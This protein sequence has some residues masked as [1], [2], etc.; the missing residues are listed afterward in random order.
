MSIIIE[1]LQKIK[2]SEFKI[3]ESPVIHKNRKLY[4][5]NFSPLEK[6]QLRQI[7]RLLFNEYIIA[8][9]KWERIGAREIMAKIPHPI[10]NDRR[11]SLASYVGKHFIPLMKKSPR[12][13]AVAKK[14][15][16]SLL[17][18]ISI[19]ELLQLEIT[20]DKHP[21]F[22]TIKEIEDT[23]ENPV[24]DPSIKPVED[25]DVIVRVPIKPTIVPPVL[26]S[27][28]V[29]KNNELIA[30][31]SGLSV[32]EKSKFN[33][34]HKGQVMDTKNAQAVFSKTMDKRKLAKINYAKGL[35]DLTK[36]DEK[37]TEQLFKTLG[38]T[39]I[40]SI[41]KKKTLNWK[42]I[43]EKRFGKMLSKKEKIKK[44]D[45]FEK[46][47]AQTFPTDFVTARVAK[48][49]APFKKFMMDNTTLDIF[50]S[51][52]NKE[53]SKQYNWKNVA[54]KDQ[55]AVRKEIQTFQRVQNLTSDVRDIAPLANS[56]YTSASAI[57]TA[58]RQ[59]FY[60]NSGLSLGKSKQVYQQAL[61]VNNESLAYL[62]MQLE[63]YRDIDFSVSNTSEITNKEK[64]TLGEI[65]YQEIFGSLHF[66]EC[67]HCNSV[68]SPAAYFVDLL[69]FLKTNNTAAFAE[70]T[71]RRADLLDIQL[72]C[73]QTLTTQP[74]LELVNEVLGK[75]LE[76][77]V[78]NIPNLSREIDD[79]LYLPWINPELPFEE[80]CMKA[81]LLANQLDT[82]LF[83][84][85]NMMEAAPE[86]QMAEYLGLGPETLKWMFLPDLLP[87]SSVQKYA[88]ETFL[89]LFN[90]DY[91]ELNLI[92]NSPVG[93]K[94]SIEVTKIDTQSYTEKIV[95]SGSSGQVRANYL[96]KLFKF[97]R[98]YRHLNYQL[99]DLELYVDL[100]TNG[101][102]LLNAVNLSKF[103]T[104][105]YVK[106]SLNLDNNALAVL[107]RGYQEEDYEFSSTQLNQKDQLVYAEVLSLLSISEIDFERLVDAFKDELNFS[108]KELLLDVNN[109][110]LLKRNIF[111]A[112][113]AGLSMKD[114]LTFLAINNTLKMV[115]N[116]NWITL[117]TQIKTYSGIGVPISLVDFYMND[118]QNESWYYSV[119]EDSV[120]NWLTLLKDGKT[121]F[122]DVDELGVAVAE[123]FGAD[124][125]LI[126]LLF[127]QY[128][129]KSD[130]LLDSVS[131]LLSLEGELDT[132]LPEFTAALDELKQLDKNILLLDF[133]EINLEAMAYFFDKVDRFGINPTNTKV[134]L[135]SLY[136]FS[137]WLNGLDGDLEIF[138]ALFDGTV[139]S[140][141][142]SEELKVIAESVFELDVSTVQKLLGAFGWDPL[143][144]GQWNR[145]FNAVELC[146]ELNWS[147]EKLEYMLQTDLITNKPREYYQQLS[148]FFDQSIQLSGKSADQMTEL[149]SEVNNKLIEA[150]RD[151]IVALVKKSTVDR[152]NSTAKIYAHF[153][154]DSE[155]SACAEV[156]PIKAAI[157]SVQL[158]IH[159]CLLNVENDN[160]GNKLQFDD[161]AKKEWEWRKNFRVWEANRK[162]FLYPENYLDPDL[163][164]DKTAI[165]EDL[166][167][168]LQQ[169]DLTLQAIEKT[170]RKYLKEF[171]NVAK[172]AMAGSFKD[173]QS[174]LYYYFGRT[175]NKPYQ[176]Y[177][178]TYAKSTRTWSPW[179]SIEVNIS[180]D[181]LAGIVVS[182]RVYIFWKELKEYKSATISDG[183]ASEYKFFRPVINYAYMEEDLGWS[184]PIEVEVKYTEVDEVTAYLED[185]FG[186]F[187]KVEQDGNLFLITITSE[188]TGGGYTE[189][190]QVEINIPENRFERSFD[191]S[192]D[193]IGALSA[194]STE[195]GI[196]LFIPSLNITEHHM[197][198]ANV[199]TRRNSETEPII[200][201]NQPLSIINGQN[202]NNYI[203]KNGEKYY[204]Y[205]FF[206]DGLYPLN[207]YVVNELS[208]VLFMDG[209]DIFLDPATQINKTEITD[210]VIHEDVILHPNNIFLP[211]QGLDFD[212]PNGIYFQELYFHIPFTLA[213]HYNNNNKYQEADYWFK[214]LFDPTI[215]FD[216]DQKYWQYTPFRTD[217]VEQMKSILQNTAALSKYHENP[218]NP[219]AIA[220]LRT[221]A[222]PKAIIMNYIDNLLDWGDSLFSQ[223][224]YESIN[225]AMMLYITA[226][227]L[228]GERPR[229]V[230]VCETANE[231]KTF[232]QIEEFLNASDEI[233]IEIESVISENKVISNSKSKFSLDKEVSDNH[234]QNKYNFTDKIQGNKSKGPIYNDVTLIQSFTQ[235]LFCIPW[236]EN[237]LGYWDLV[238]NRMYK[239]R[240][241]MN[242]DG[243]Y[244]QLALFEPPIDPNL[245]VRARSAGLN[246]SQLTAKTQ[247]LPYRFSYLLEKARFFANTV[248]S[249]GQAMLSA[250]EKESGEALS[251]LR[252]IHEGNILEMVTL[253]KEKL[254]DE[255]NTQTEIND[256]NTEKIQ[257]SIAYYQELM[258]G[259]VSGDFKIA[260]QK[261][262]VSM[263][264]SKTA[265]LLNL[266]SS[267]LYMIPQLG[268][269]TA[270]TF[271]GK[272]S[273]DSAKSGT[274]ALIALGEY[275][276]MGAEI[277]EKYQNQNIRNL[278]WKNGFDSSQK[279]LKT[280]EK[281]KLVNEIKLAVAQRDLETHKQRIAQNEEA[282]DFYTEKMS[283]QALYNHLK[284]HLTRLYRDAYG[285]AMQTA[286]DA[287]AAYQF[288]TSNDT[289]FYI[290]PDNWDAA[291]M[292]LLATEKLQNQLMLLERAHMEQ[293]SRKA[294][295]KTHV[296][297][298][299]IDAQALIAFK[300]TGECDFTIP[301]EWFDIQYP[302]QYKRRI[303]S[304]SV[305]IPCITGPYVNIPCKLKLQSS[306]MRVVTNLSSALEV[307]PTIPDGNDRIFTSSAQN[308]AGLLE[309]SFKDERYLP[310]EGAGVD[311]IWNLQLPSKLR[312]FNYNTISDVIFHVSYT[313]EY[314]GT[315]RAE[316]EENIEANINA[317]NSNGGLVKVMSLKHE[318]PNEWYQAIAE[319]EAMEITLTENHFSYFT[320]SGN[321]SLQ[322]V[323]LEVIDTNEPDEDTSANSTVD[324]ASGTLPKT[325]T[326]TI[327]EDEKDKELFLVVSYK[328]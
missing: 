109:L 116:N 172:L 135:I 179:T 169:R 57:L 26:G 260:D 8:F 219:H 194:N 118:V 298:A 20:I 297:M 323:A 186:G 261:F 228:L 171:S 40:K 207:S 13:R 231:D 253:S 36:G 220:R 93:S 193:D 2:K 138:E 289:D 139:A 258:G 106:D 35:L 178:K 166:E 165:Y 317:L 5:P 94:L 95:V 102:G 254:I 112:N 313:A 200:T 130:Q 285:V 37:L 84:I 265:N 60:K 73:N 72:N 133:L 319:N 188:T 273:G 190:I 203:I 314:D 145:F 176:Y 27:G 25:D 115:V 236:N 310:F 47:V 50:S 149:Y 201:S 257:T 59:E 68:F 151:A 259:T 86:V 161:E 197:W 100:A 183:D 175:D 214:K 278:G 301:E 162:V 167:G 225:E 131:T 16:L 244:R 206:N 154:L 305:S 292:G 252:A 224:T 28:R 152:L 243:E 123:L 247:L 104:M 147:A 204:Q 326:V 22:H 21:V 42:E 119:N 160:N 242:I 11:L 324:N 280:N 307:A 113:G 264:L 306:R 97:L 53:D 88:T 54:S 62:N 268:A 210:L 122:V 43:I 33:S 318:F 15:D 99:A 263:D 192:D 128:P 300:N 41:A 184:K 174:N 1:L 156:S 76:N 12:F 181:Y 303:K 246:L 286:M 182:G 103:S 157:L 111:W 308:D 199:Y 232:K 282:L 45:E 69:Y 287:Q 240:N 56:G 187:L 23:T 227:Q 221:G 218:F 173:V 75:Y 29:N 3:F 107:I 321:L 143:K 299:L 222:Y 327:D 233:L 294:E 125:Q 196:E 49:S 276:K 322:E 255:L 144:L 266:L 296:S 163:R 275:A 153:L 114:W 230:A 267:A 136:N 189:E 148:A 66:C 311:S 117:I 32:D 55:P 328:L 127:E 304:V 215:E 17:P 64:E 216:T 158:F 315:L 67:E 309:F 234:L 10:F 7:M 250:I 295:V 124:D 213:K 71:E 34:K 46:E 87:A 170:Y 63:R 61:D 30:R 209:I 251:E 239:I 284:G 31:L 235:E 129:A 83:D 245:L 202:T 283:N 90:L 14:I 271:G 217:I 164:D 6:K 168:D 96:K 89:N 80:D 185:L 70:L 39:S 132:I 195:E 24:E 121:T 226:H 140:G 150:K 44:A 320:Q 274:Q 18:E 281:A 238:E 48:T 288:E 248:H 291:S 269:P 277:A 191:L 146:S 82:S 91:D 134:L 101:T 74:Y 9:Y 4:N 290:A 205:L 81:R 98:L 159:R 38:V 126:Q 256:I 79:I 312:S 198:N 155:M 293:N 105:M 302:G 229:S 78:P 262:T 108:S 110:S 92:V 58:N 120:A 85:Y 325:F 52:F 272:Q 142:L 177:Y 241:C 316:V 141:E 137:K 279:D 19:S 180:S 51:R 270:M 223:D 249:F 212:G 237:L 208:E 65:D 211:E 77:N